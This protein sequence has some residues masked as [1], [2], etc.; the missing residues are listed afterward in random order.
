MYSSV[1]PFAVFHILARNIELIMT[2]DQ[3]SKYAA[4]LLEQ[5]SKLLTDNANNIVL[6]ICFHKVSLV[7]LLIV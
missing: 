6:E 5:A 4:E 2:D 1:L 7:A 3:V